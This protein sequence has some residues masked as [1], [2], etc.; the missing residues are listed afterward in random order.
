MRLLVVGFSVQGWR[1]QDVYDALS[2]G[3]F[4]S[5]AHYDNVFRTIFGAK[6]HNAKGVGAQWQSIEQFRTIRNAYVHGTR[7]SS[8]LRLEAGVHLLR[9]AVLHPSWLSTLPVRAEAGTL[10]LGDPYRRLHP[11][12]T[13]ARS[14]TELRSLIAEAR[15]RR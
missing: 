12:R 8:P 4:H 15:P 2:A 5:A 10:P 6:P 14:A 9:E 1:V 7:G 3:R 11:R 13:G